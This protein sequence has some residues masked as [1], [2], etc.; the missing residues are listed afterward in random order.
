MSDTDSVSLKI[1]SP[2]ARQ[3][4]VAAQDLFTTRRFNEITMD[5]VCRA[6]GVGKGTIYRYFRD[7]D[8]LF[9]RT[10]TAGLGELCTLLK[11]KSLRRG[12]FEHRLTEACRAISKYFNSRKRMFH[13]LQV[14]EMC[15]GTV[16]HDFSEGRKALIEALGEILA[17]GAHE[18]KLS[19]KIS[20]RVLANL[21]LG[22]L[23]AGAK[24][25][26]QAP[27][28]YQRPEFIVKFFLRGAK[29]YQAQ[30]ELS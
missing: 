27:D 16:R 10:A 18:G 17:S 23:R 19:S 20:P 1:E 24:D 5:D 11:N 3:I 12:D 9:V 4:M 30:E 26:T 21:L 13:M 8:D 2:K 7:K 28:Q 6:A 15:H 29:G 25:L 14:Q 22:L